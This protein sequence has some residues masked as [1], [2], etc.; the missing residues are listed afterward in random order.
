MSAQALPSSNNL[1]IDELVLETPRILPSSPQYSLIPRI[2]IAV[3]PSGSIHALVTAPVDL[4]LGALVH[5]AVQR[6]IRLVRTV[7]HLVAHQMAID[8]LPIGAGELTLRTR[9]VLLLA[10]HLVRMVTAVVLP[11]A[12]VLIAD[13]LEVLAGELLRRTGLVL[14]VAVLALVRTVAAVVVVIAYPSLRDVGLIGL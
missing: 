12:P 6:F 11:V 14:A 7:R 10:V 2:T 4:H 1:E 8:A 13:A 9:V 5:V 3:V